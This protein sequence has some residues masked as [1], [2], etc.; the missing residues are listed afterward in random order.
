MSILSLSSQILLL[1]QYIGCIV[2]IQ[3]DHPGQNRLGAFRKSA[4]ANADVSNIGA[5]LNFHDKGGGKDR[6]KKISRHWT[7]FRVE[8][9]NEQMQVFCQ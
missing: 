7:R 5:A 6:K 1:L 8:I 9:T 2:F 4:K 3:N